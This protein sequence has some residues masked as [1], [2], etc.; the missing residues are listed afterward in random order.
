MKEELCNAFCG[1][2][3][4]REV[5]AGLA[6]STAFDGADGDPIG[7]YIV[8]PDES[9]LFRL[10]DSGALIPFI[11]ASGATLESATRR[12][13]FNEILT[14]YN[15]V[16]DDDTSELVIPSLQQKDVPTAALR[17]VALLLRI[18]DIL[19]MAH[20]RAAST[21]REDAL[22]AI[23]ESLGHKAEIKE[24]EPVSKEL[25]DTPADVLI[26]AKGRVPVAL[27]WGTSDVKIMEAMLLQ[28][29]AAYHHNIRCSVVALI[30]HSKS[31]SPKNWQRAMNRLDATPMYRGEEA[32]S[33]A[34]VCKEVLGGEALH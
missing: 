17:F 30:E 10:E 24:N 22:R 29:D 7:F 19:F 16:Y 13:V 27:F 11:E 4:V 20:E 5:P 9:G 2:L 6:V 3:N 25:K 34:R 15:A 14:S 8:G 31:I 33:I 12:E 28:G 23:T 21:F 18:Q 26:R 1:D 32:Q